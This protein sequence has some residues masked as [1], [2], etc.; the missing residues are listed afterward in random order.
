MFQVESSV[1]ICVCFAFLCSG[2][3][4][5]EPAEADKKEA[6]KEGKA[7]VSHPADY[8]VVKQA[9][10]EL[11]W[12]VSKELKNSETITMGKAVIKPGFENPRHFHPN[13][14]EVLHVLQGKILHSM[15][16][17]KKVEMS[18]G[19]TVTIPA[20]TGHNAKN[21]G[22]EDAVMIICYSSAERKMV[23]E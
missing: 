19:D 10:G 17:G 8:Q 9:W 3:L 20:N 21:I 11:T 16:G 6:R 1:L 13:C 22:T 15:E 23:N 4:A 14:D 5:A 7:I 2:V 12:F 18:A